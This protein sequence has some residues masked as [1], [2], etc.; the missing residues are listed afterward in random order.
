MTTWEY[1]GMA[2]VTEVNKKNGGTETMLITI[3]LPN[4]VKPETSLSTLTELNK[5]GKEGWEVVSVT[6][7]NFTFGVINDYL[8]KRPISE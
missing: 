6:P 3:G 4:K 8:L 1:A 7:R 2:V 5:L